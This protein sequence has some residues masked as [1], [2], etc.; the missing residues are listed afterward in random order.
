VW[1]EVVASNE[2]VIIAGTSE[3][4]ASLRVFKGTCRCCRT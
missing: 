3:G 1:L 4:L 2:L